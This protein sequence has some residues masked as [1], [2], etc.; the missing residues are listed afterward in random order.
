MSKKFAADAHREGGT[1]Q[2]EGNEMMAGGNFTRRPH[3]A[4]DRGKPEDPQLKNKKTLTASGKFMR[5]SP[6]V[7]SACGTKVGVKRT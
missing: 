1:G 7:A 6:F 2:P 4:F 5:I 3:G